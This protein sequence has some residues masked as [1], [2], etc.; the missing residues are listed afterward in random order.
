VDVAVQAIARSVAESG[1]EPAG[2]LADEPLTPAEIAELK[3]RFR[4]LRD[5][6]KV[7][8][9]KVNAQEDLLL[10]E[11]RE[12]T[13]RGVCQHLLGKVDRKRVFAAAERMS[14]PEAAR[15]IEGVLG[16]SP[17]V[18]YVL[19]YLDCVRRAG[20][21]RQA[22]AALAEALERID[23]AQASPGQMR[24]VLDLV[25]E[26]FDVA[27][28]PSMLLGLLEG[29]AF[30]QAFDAVA[31][32]L[33]PALAR[34]VLPLRAAQGVVL[35]ARANPGGAAPLREGI[36]LLLH[37]DGPSLARLPTPARRRL[38]ELGAD[39]WAG[40]DATAT[41]ALLQLL[42]GLRSHDHEHGELG[43]HL[44][45]A[46]LRNRRDD[47]A[48]RLLGELTRAHPDFELP[49]RWLR[50]LESPRLGRIA[51]AA[52]ALRRGTGGPVPLTKGRGNGTDLATMR[53]VRVFFAP[54]EH[55]SE[56]EET[57]RLLALVAG[58]TSESSRWLA[59]PAIGDPLD[60]LLER[61]GG[62]S[63]ATALA[64]TRAAVAILSALA[65]AGAVLPEAHPR[66]FEVDPSGHPWLVDVRRLTAAPVEVANQQMLDQARGF[67]GRVL[68][69]ARRFVPPAGLLDTLAQ[70]GSFAELYRRLV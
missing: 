37:G 62:A 46:L 12:P 24:R 42:E 50:A 29:S 60:E 19:L 34:L 43:M 67:V 66:R 35:H 6:R 49:R 59:V 15:F 63:R 18:D 54:P 57:E 21:H 58:G 22:I 36:R 53:P 7:L 68:D 2:K 56:M 64:V 31:P 45:G 8:N 13:H 47:E 26:L 27:S 9:L 33:P 5:Y 23:F 32:D 14:A 69:G 30:R 61:R 70:I 52:D 44:A 39:A 25:V 11:R 16:L 20:A 28:L 51:L 65:N 38:L 10:N 41:Q 55:G 48:R 3:R 1:S 4:F 17:D 40:V